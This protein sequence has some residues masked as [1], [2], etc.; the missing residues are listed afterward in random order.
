MKYNNRYA[1]KKLKEGV[2]LEIEGGTVKDYAGKGDNIVIPRDDNVN[3]RPRVRLLRGVKRNYRA[4]GGENTRF[5][6]RRVR[7]KNN[8]KITN[9][10]SRTRVVINH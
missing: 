9:N 2:E 4:E 8:R 10:H 1:D 5:R 3:R 6:F 7:S